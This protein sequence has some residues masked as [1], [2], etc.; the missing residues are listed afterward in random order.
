MEGIGYPYLIKQSTGK[1]MRVF[2]K[3]NTGISMSVL[4]KNG[5][6][7]EATPLVKTFTPDF[8]A[9]IDPKDNLHILCQDAFGNILH[10]TSKN[11]LWNSTPVLNSRNPS[12]YDKHLYIT[13][14]GD[15]TYFLYCLAHEGKRLLSYQYRNAQG[16]LSK[17]KVIDYLPDGGKPFQVIKDSK[18]QL[19]LFYRF[20][21]NRH[22]QL[23]YRTYNPLN[24]QLGEFYPITEYTGESE[25]LAA[26]SDEDL[27]LHVCWQRKS[28]QKHEL[29]Y[30]RKQKN[31]E[32][33]DTQTLLQ[34]SDKPFDTFSLLISDNR[35]TACR[36]MENS[37]SYSTSRDSG[38]TWSGWEEQ[39]F[40]GGTPYMV[41]YLTNIPEGDSYA[42]YDTIPVRVSGD[43]FRLAFLDKPETGENITDA[44][45]L[46]FLITNTMK[47]LSANYHTL[48]RAVKEMNYTVENI[49]AQQN[50]IE[51]SME[52]YDTKM[53]LMEAL[54]AKF[55]AD[56][57]S[58]KS[59]QEPHVR[60]LPDIAGYEE[61]EG[62]VDENY[63]VMP[64]TGFS[65]ITAQYLRNLKK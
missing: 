58:L 54:L 6:W 43:G 5:G 19:H 30:S 42:F 57:D 20:V 31:S 65:T 14:A 8:S 63:P 50:R 35:I 17:P 60:H 36:L 7:Q 39:P 64:G 37:V 48:S 15:N 13:H 26:V 12:R 41:H 61:N 10:M 33:W 40:S 51:L 18:Q 44:D 45:E 38:S 4:G 59:L 52:R 62:A 16:V 49:T 1:T 28:A 24:G 25:V 21:D 27:N 32:A 2:Y 29:L 53:E 9:C 22:S 46:R 56:L 47:E 23:G 55:T 3:E 11:G 34:A